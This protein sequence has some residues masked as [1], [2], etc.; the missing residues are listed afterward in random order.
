MFFYSSFPELSMKKCVESD[1]E[2]RSSIDS[3]GRSSIESA[4]SND[5]DSNGSQKAA[6]QDIW[7][8]IVLDCSTWTYTDS[9]GVETVRE[10]SGYGQEKPLLATTYIDK[11]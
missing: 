8:T 6:K 10:V 3:E 4:D 9:M 11:S 7:R 2:G 1:S 5:S